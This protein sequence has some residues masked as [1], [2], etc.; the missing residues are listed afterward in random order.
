MAALAGATQATHAAFHADNTVDPNFRG[1]AIDAP[2]WIAICEVVPHGLAP[3]HTA[4]V[5]GTLAETDIEASIAETDQYT[6]VAVT[7]PTEVNYTATVRGI[8]SA[9]G[10]QGQ[11]YP[12]AGGWTTMMEAGQQHNEAMLRYHNET[13]LDHV[14]SLSN[15][16][17]IS[18]TLG[19]ASFMDVKLALMTNQPIGQVYN[20]VMHV[21][22]FGNLIKDI[23]A[24][25]NGRAIYAEGLA[26]MQQQ[27]LMGSWEGVNL[28]TSNMIDQ[29]DGTNWKG[30]ICCGTSYDANIYPAT[31]GTFGGVLRPSGL[32]G[33]PIRMTVIEWVARQTGSLI[34]DQRLGDQMLT[35][36]FFGSGI[37]DNKQAEAW[38]AKKT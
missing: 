23:Q 25:A 1:P 31:P 24:T 30:A 20:S 34:S 12:G 9:I 36:S 4:N 18:A 21:S 29:H 27:G 28:Y 32:I 38:T 33:G 14:A 7:A 15:V 6:N 5:R 3:T 13:I 35:Y 19:H 11:A 16:T 2:V 17:T 10:L 26:Q 37:I 8:A 22:D